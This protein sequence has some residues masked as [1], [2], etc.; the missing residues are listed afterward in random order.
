MV[1]GKTEKEHNLTLIRVLQRL[2]DCGPTLNLQKCF[3]SI[4]KIEFFGFIFSTQ[5]AVPTQVRTT[6]LINATRPTIPEF[7]SK[8]A[9]LQA[10]T[11]KNDRF[12]WLDK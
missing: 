9:S 10:L 4:P 2:Q 3:F 7:S 6:T 12:T 1:Y 5:G 8:T 11:M